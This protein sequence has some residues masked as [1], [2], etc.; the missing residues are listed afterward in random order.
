V[1]PRLPTDDSFSDHRR[2][3]ARWAADHTVAIKS[4]KPK[5]PKWLHDRQKDNWQPLLQIAEVLDADKYP[6]MTRKVIQWV[7]KRT[8]HDV[9]EEVAILLRDVWDWFKAHASE[10]VVRSTEL[11]EYLAQR[12]DRPW[13][14]YRRTGKPIT[15]SALARLLKPHGLSTKKLWLARS[16]KYGNRTI[17][18][19]H[20]TQFT[21]TGVV[22]R[23][24]CKKSPPRPPE[25]KRAK[26]YK[27][28]SP[29]RAEL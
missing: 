19:Y 22:M 7:E 2:K 27:G 5:I 18:G 4:A 14:E 13:Q 3:A 17:Q 9:D 24:A 16:K 1:V 10:D 25:P 12:E 8:V 15:P 28:K 29:P 11:C 26:G 6:R 23:Y 21:R 20:R